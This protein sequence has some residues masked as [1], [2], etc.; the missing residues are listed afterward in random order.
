MTDL[1]DAI[2]DHL[3]GTAV[4]PHWVGGPLHLAALVIEPGFTLSQRGNR[5]KERQLAQAVGWPLTY[6]EAIHGANSGLRS[7]ED[8]RALAISVFSAVRPRQS[9]TVVGKVSRDAAAW[10]CSKVHPLVCGQDCPL[11][12]AALAVVTAYREGRPFTD[13]F[14]EGTCCRLFT[15][16]ERERVVPESPAGHH[17]VV[18]YRY[19]FQALSNVKDHLSCADALREAVRA[20]T[21]AR[22][23]SGAVEMCLELARRL[24][25]WSGPGW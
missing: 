5:F 9:A 10:T 13:P 18:A 17:S 4:S 23:M 8:R 24:G 7:E 25:L 3:V 2:C 6:C 20:Q 11:H 22:G 1:Q 19:L 15:G 16:S 21:K 14:A 12:V